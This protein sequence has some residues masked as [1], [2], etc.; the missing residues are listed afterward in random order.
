MLES[1]LDSVD[2]WSPAPIGSK[3]ESEIYLEADYGLDELSE[4]DEN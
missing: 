3:E 4:D 1:D 2:H